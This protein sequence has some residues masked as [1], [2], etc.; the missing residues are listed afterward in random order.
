MMLGVEA[1]GCQNQTGVPSDPQKTAFPR[2][3]MLYARPRGWRSPA[4]VTKP[5]RK[6]T[7]ATNG[8]ATEMAVPAPTLI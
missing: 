4:P 7:V 3:S 2:L 6:A 5:A 8:P 1:A